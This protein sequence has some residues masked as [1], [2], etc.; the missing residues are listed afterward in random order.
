MRDGRGQN[1][2]VTTAAIDSLREFDLELNHEILVLVVN[3]FV[4]FRRDGIES[5]VLT[6]L[7]ALVGL[8]VAVPIGGSQLPVA[9]CAVGLFPI[10]RRPS[11]L[12]SG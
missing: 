4:E 11:F 9:G 5:R 7:N 8:G 12:P 6:R 10:G 1:F 2:D 3:W